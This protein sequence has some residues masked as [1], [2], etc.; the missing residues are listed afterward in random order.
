MTG[1]WN[2]ICV[3]LFEVWFSEKERKLVGNVEE[4]G[5]ITLSLE[6]S[7]QVIYVKILTDVRKMLCEVCERISVKIIEAECYPDYIYVLVSIPLQLSY[8]RLWDVLKVGE[9][10]KYLATMRL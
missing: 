9:A 10:S 6:Y 2:C 1:H 8:H 4:N 3:R 7:E 5:S